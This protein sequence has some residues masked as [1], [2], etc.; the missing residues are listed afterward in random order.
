MKALLVFL[1]F[2]VTLAKGCMTQTTPLTLSSSTQETTPTDS[3]QFDAQV[4][5]IF[6]TRCSPC[7]FTGGKMYAKM[8]FDKAETI[9]SHKDGILKRIKNEK[10]NELI[11]AFVMQGG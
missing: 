6:V 5:P 8:P 11:K 4:K 1:I 9:I 2:I 3:I 10:E 7:H